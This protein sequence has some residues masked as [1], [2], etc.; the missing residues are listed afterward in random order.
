MSPVET[1]LFVEA[2]YKAHAAAVLAKLR[3]LGIEGPALHDLLQDVFV[4]AW[5]RYAKIPKDAADARRWLLDS[6]RKHAANF[7]RLHR[8]KYEELDP[9]AIEVARAEPEDPEAQAELSNLVWSVLRELDEPVRESL[10]RHH[11]VGESLE[12]LGARLGL[13]KSGVHARLQAAEERM[14]ALVP[15]HG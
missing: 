8:H 3:R 5:R 11:V 12:E 9:H 2:L 15:R 13:T 14:R 1:A 7:H 4:V 10:V 6:A